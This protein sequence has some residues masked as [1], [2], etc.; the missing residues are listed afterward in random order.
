MKAY[1]ASIDHFILLDRLAEYVKDRASRS[2]KLF[3]V[4]L[5]MTCRTAALAPPR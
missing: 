3:L 5:A 4:S 2:T 1:Y